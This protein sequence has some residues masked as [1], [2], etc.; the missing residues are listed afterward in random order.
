M[1]PH[2]ALVMNLGSLH[3]LVLIAGLAWHRRDRLCRS[4]LVYVIAVFLG[5]RLVVTWPDRFDTAPFWLFKEAVYWVLKLAVATEVGLLTFARLPRGRRLVAGVLAALAVLA[6]LVQLLPA[7]SRPGDAI[8]W[9]SVASPRGQAALV[10]VLLAVVLLAAQHYRAPIHPFHR[11][12][13]IGFG[14]YLIA[15]TAGLTMLREVGAPAY[16]YF[17]ALDSTAYNAT[18]GVWVWAAWRRA[19]ELSPGA[20]ILQPWASQSW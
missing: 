19:P 12:L 20:R 17:L 13:L 11:S 3:L 6:L 10:V 16:R 9:V 14:L 8:A 2:R 18:V 7:A 1:D 5:D 15:Y 4:F